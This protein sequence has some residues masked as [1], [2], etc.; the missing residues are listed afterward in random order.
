LLLEQEDECSTTTTEDV[1]FDEDPAQQDVQ[2]ADVPAVQERCPTVNANDARVEND[3]SNSNNNDY[4]NAPTDMDID[5]ETH[6]PPEPVARDD[7]A[8]ATAAS[9]ASHTTTTFAA[10]TPA[11]PQRFGNPS[12]PK[13][14]LFKSRPG[15]GRVST[16]TGEWERLL[17]FKPLPMDPSSIRNVKYVRGGGE[18]NV[19]EIFVSSYNDT[20]GSTKKVDE[21]EEGVGTSGARKSYRLESKEDSIP[22]V[23]LAE[24]EA[25]G[26]DVKGV[27]VTSATDSA[28]RG[29]TKPSTL[30]KTSG[31][32]KY[33]NAN[34]R[35][36]KRK[37]PTAES[38]PAASKENA[39]PAAKKAP[40]KCK[41][42]CRETASVAAKGRSKTL[43]K[44]VATK[45]KSA[46]SLVNEKGKKLKTA[47]G[48]QLAAAAAAFELTNEEKCESADLLYMDSITA[49]I[50]KKVLHVVTSGLSE[51]DTEAFK[52]LCKETKNNHGTLFLR[53]CTVLHNQNDFLLTV[54]PPLLPCLALPCLAFF[55][56]VKVKLTE[57]FKSD[58]TTLCVVAVEP[59]GANGGNLVAGKRT[60]KAMQA[61]MAGVPLVSPAWITSCVESSHQFVL[62]D[63]SMFVRTLPTKTTREEQI[64]AFGVSA[65]AAAI[66]SS[67][68][69][70]ATFHFQILNDISVFLCGRFETTIAKL[71]REAGAEV[72]TASST[73][74]AKL[75]ADGDPQVVLLCSDK[76]CKIP[77]SVKSQVQIHKS[78]VRVVNTDW[79]FDSISCGSVLA[80][81]AYAPKVKQ[82]KELWALTT[83]AN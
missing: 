71:L 31:N 54:C 45:R 49:A 16:S 26:F 2:A 47:E 37:L 76:D 14:L 57:S 35:S 1:P 42:K 7:P 60:L 78:Q 8:A 67:R 58:K 38:G 24:L 21:E 51:T 3:N 12:L 68:V 18:T 53:Y 32:T 22:A 4:V 79:L 69:Q 55:I 73:V 83:D 44:T 72:L 64:M 66:R 41:S 52:K 43:N 9:V 59:R 10:E 25:K 11:S 75:S 28:V 29:R 77:G 65:I 34:H 23:L 20:L 13:I 80:A 56:L 70:A 36:G 61:G 74:V 46:V 6:R 17:E 48:I 81:G 19:E 63:S 82:A 62:P 40:G 50:E 39:K 5:N 27:P 15:R 33:L 30:N